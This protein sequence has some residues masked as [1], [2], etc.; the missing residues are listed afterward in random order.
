MAHLE[1]LRTND[2]DAIDFQKDE[3][4][5]AFIRDALDL[6]GNEPTAARTTLATIAIVL[7]VWARKYPELERRFHS[8]DTWDFLAPVCDLD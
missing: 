5:L 1:N 6:H 7:S 2:V 3:A 8:D 4:V